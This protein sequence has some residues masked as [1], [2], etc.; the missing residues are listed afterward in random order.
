MNQATLNIAIIGPGNVG[1]AFMRQIST[2]SAL[3][4][5]AIINSKKM[6]LSKTNIDISTMSLDTILTLDSDFNKF[7]AFLSTCHPCVVV[8]CT[9]SHYIASTY[10][11]LLKKGLSIVTPNKK[12]FSDALDLYKQIKHLSASKWPLCYHESSVGAGLPLLSTIQ[13][14]VQTGD[15]IQSICGVFSGTLSYIFNT[16]SSPLNKQTFSQIVNEAKTKGYTEPVKQ[17]NMH[18]FI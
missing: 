14:L 10:P 13:D 18:L 11:A 9:A 6:A 7:E 15:Y 12:A 2:N 17:T 4:L 16:F 8:D 5:V 3:N 1:K